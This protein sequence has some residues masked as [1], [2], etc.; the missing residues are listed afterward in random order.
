MASPYDDFLAESIDLESTY[1]AHLDYVY[2]DLAYS[3]GQG[4]LFGLAAYGSGAD[5]EFVVNSINLK[6]SYFDEELWGAGGRLPGRLGGRAQW[7]LWPHPW[8]V[9]MQAPCM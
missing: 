5:S 9:T 1:I 6:G 2:Q 4:K 3:Y 7:R 8:L